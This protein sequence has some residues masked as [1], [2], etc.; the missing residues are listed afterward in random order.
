MPFSG[1]RPYGRAAEPVMPESGR[2][3]P[4]MPIATG[5][6]EAEAELERDAQHQISEPA[7]ADTRGTQR[8]LGDQPI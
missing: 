8:L 7:L 1:F 4:V 5:K 3:G 6:P 2:I